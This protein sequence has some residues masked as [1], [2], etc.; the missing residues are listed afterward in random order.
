[1][2][3]AIALATFLLAACA[4][5]Q[6]AVHTPAAFAQTLP[7][8]SLAHWEDKYPFGMQGQYNPFF[9]EP[10]VKAAMENTVPP[11]LMKKL[12][13]WTLNVPFKRQGDILYAWFMK[14]HSGGDYAAQIFF[15]LKSSTIQLCVTELDMKRNRKNC[16][17]YG[18][19]VRPLEEG[20]CGQDNFESFKRYGEK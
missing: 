18:K 7:A 19:T 16:T 6:A 10:I 12:M 5:I 8:A 3:T 13:G 20:A 11:A 1:M 14:P 4:L 15:D 2:R 9:D 17:W